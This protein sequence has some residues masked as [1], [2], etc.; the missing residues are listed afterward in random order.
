[1]LKPNHYLELANEYLEKIERLKKD[2]QNH[3]SLR[4]KS[5]K[6]QKLLDA[7]QEYRTRFR[8]RTS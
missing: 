3:Y 4:E 8:D 2:S 1:M 6:E 5:M 7:Y